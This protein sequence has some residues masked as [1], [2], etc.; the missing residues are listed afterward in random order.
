MYE[1]TSSPSTPADFERVRQVEG[2]ERIKAEFPAYLTDESKM[3]P[4]PFD[5][6]FFPKDEAEL[7]AIVREM[8]RCRVKITIAAA[9][10][11]LVGGCVPIEGALVSLENMD[12]IEAVY[13][14]PEADEWRV[15]VQ[16]GVSLQA[17]N[18][19]L[20]FKSFPNIERGGNQITHDHLVRFKET[21]ETYFY[22]PDPTE[23]SASMGGTTATNASGARTYRY[24]PTRDWVRGLRVLL[25]NGE[26]LDIP[27]G[28][29]FS[30]PAGEFVIYDSAGNDYPVKVPDY[31]MPRTKNTSG[32]FS[33]PH[34]D[35]ID[36]FIGS[37]GAFGIIT[38]VDVAML[39]QQSKVSIVQFLKSDEQAIELTEALR[40]E[41]RLRLDFL[42]FY[43][44]KAIEMLR[45]HQKAEPAAVGMP[46]IPENA[47]SAIFFE[48]SF[49]PLAED[50]DFSAL[51]ETIANCGASLADS[52][53][54]YEIRELDRFKA[55]RH[56]L[57]EMINAIIADRKKEYPALHKL[58]T[59]LAVPDE[60]LRALWQVY[61]EGLDSAGLQW[62]AFGHIG[63]NHIHVNVL[64]RNM[65]ELEKGLELYNEFARKAV[66][67]GGA[68]SAE[69]G[70][71]K[72][73]AKFLKAMFTQ[74]QIS[75][76]RRIK[77]AL[78][79]QGLFN[80]GNIFAD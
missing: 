16:C 59:D 52:W 7:A 35:L 26:F 78:D 31:P 28:K 8:N 14:V 6:L 58:G 19:A 10:T 69:H 36:L 66:E 23:L 40:T 22:P 71:G 13:F 38:A 39:K 63:N 53:A 75:Q 11:G 43:S 74:E 48:L 18:Q 21:P 47:G 60:Y 32:F 20:K 25:A 50:I 65:E 33:A 76:M 80:P 1:I 62:V 12:Q 37:E 72:I 30:S 68:V 54:G 3:S 44:E 9:R 42:E 24:G 41:K 17:L 61:H 15:R 49:D 45:R 77:E 57:P 34:M 51:E 56:I 2:F 64:P 55:F 70:I 79:P 67:F 4:Q 27:R 46:P 29:Y 5:Y 73:K